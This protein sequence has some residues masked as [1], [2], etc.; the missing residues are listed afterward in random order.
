[1]SFILLN[2]WNEF[3]TKYILSLLNFILNRYI[4]QIF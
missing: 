4:L 3:K 2:F 1:M